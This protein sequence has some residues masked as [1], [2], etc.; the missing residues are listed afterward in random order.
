MRGLYY[1]S[2]CTNARKNL[3]ILCRCYIRIPLANPKKAPQ[4]PFVLPTHFTAVVPTNLQTFCT[5]SHISTCTS[6]AFGLILQ[7]YSREVLHTS[8]GDIEHE[9]YTSNT[10]S[11]RSTRY[12]PT[13]T[14]I[15]RRYSTA[16]IRSVR[17]NKYKQVSPKWYSSSVICG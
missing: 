2:L 9:Q 12:A 11:T 13:Y 14:H 17:A 3:E 5:L 8:L 15:I 6:C 16:L 1:K 7:G 4:P 10:R